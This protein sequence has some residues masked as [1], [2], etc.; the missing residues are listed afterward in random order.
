MKLEFLKFLKSIT[1]WQIKK[2][3][4]IKQCSTGDTCINKEI[5]THGN[6][7]VSLTYLLLLC[8]NFISGL[9][10]TTLYLY[11]HSHV[12]VQCCCVL[13]PIVYT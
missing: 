12:A 2:Q 4:L 6:Q 1:Y 13:L 7:Q 8:N 3:C 9:Q 11:Y 5:N 10:E